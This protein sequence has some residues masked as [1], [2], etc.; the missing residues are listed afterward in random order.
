LVGLRP[1]RPD[2]LD[3]V[4][5]LE[6][7]PDQRPFI[8]Q[9]S[10]EQHLEAIARG[11]REH[12]VIEE[13]GEGSGDGRR[14]GYLIAYDVTAAG[15]GIYVKR[16]ALSEKSTGAGRRAIHAFL[17]HAF[18]DLGAAWVCLAVRRHNLR[19]QRAYAAIGFV[20]WPLDQEARQRMTATVD[21]FPEEC[22]VMRVDPGSVRAPDSVD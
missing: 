11:D 20:E 4:L 3:F 12:W 6:H 9:W 13:H 22:F 19:A 18:D 15:Y 21:A 5:A 1:T 8:G 10:R 17:R 2:D 14:L 16:V 7:H